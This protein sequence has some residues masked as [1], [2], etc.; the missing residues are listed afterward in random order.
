MKTLS[1][2]CPCGACDVLVW[3]YDNNGIIWLY[4]QQCYTAKMAYQNFLNL[5]LD[6][7]DTNSILKGQ[8]LGIA[9]MISK[10][11]I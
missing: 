9:T 3:K 2:I 4:C 10:E 7:S 1:D 8:G 6:H 11:A 5:S